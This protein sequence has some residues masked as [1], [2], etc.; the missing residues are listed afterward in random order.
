M[1]K[2]TIAVTMVK[3]EEDVIRAVLRHMEAQVDGI[4]I[5]D[6]MSTDRTLDILTAVA[7]GSSIHVKIVVDHQVGYTQSVKMT[8]LADIARKQMGAKWIVPFDADE[9]WVPTHHKRLAD[10]P[11]NIGPDA[12]VVP[13][14]LFDYVA[15]GLDD[16]RQKNPIKRLQWRRGYEAELPKVMCQW[17]SDM[18]IGMGN[19]DV[20]YATGKAEATEP[21]IEIKH[22]PYRT[23][24]QVV[25][26]IRNGARA[27]EAT[28]LPD[29]Y[30][31]HWRQWGQILELQGEEAIV[32]LFHKW[33]WRE[34]PTVDFEID[35]DH[36]PALIY[37][38]VQA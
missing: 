33:H 2:K 30:G 3:D 38:P 10:I 14:A 22:F 20:S 35:G 6:N 9:I 31:A 7:E 16:A 23:A 8:A 11:L 25:R 36:Q 27:Y 19:H 26:K 28:K 37:D 1:N 13:A 24:E 15:T 5:A 21:L 32:E 34:D 18:K 12:N 4:L 17:R 29:H